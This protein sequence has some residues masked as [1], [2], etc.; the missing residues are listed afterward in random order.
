MFVA[1]AEYSTVQLFLSI[2]CDERNGVSFYDMWSQDCED[3]V[4]YEWKYAPFYKRCRTLGRIMLGT[5][6]GP[7]I[8]VEIQPV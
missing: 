2:V 6:N 5:C 3:Q 1:C 4:Y 8:H 7:D